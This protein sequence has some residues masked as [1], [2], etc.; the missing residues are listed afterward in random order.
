MSVVIVTL[1][2]HLADATARAAATLAR[3]VPGL[4]LS[5][6]AASDWEHDA[7]SLQRCRED[8][9]GGDIVIATMLFMED[10][11]GAVLPALAARRDHCDAMVCA[12]S[13][14]TEHVILP[15]CFSA[16]ILPHR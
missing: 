13:A 8:I 11:I 16:A 2:G 9:A 6:H 7:Q 4:A 14:L 15:S 3:E 5:L 10:H 12:M 1:D